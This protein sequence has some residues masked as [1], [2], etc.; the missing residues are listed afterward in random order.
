MLENKKSFSCVIVSL[1]QNGDGIAYP[2]RPHRSK[3]YVISSESSVLYRNNPPF[4]AISS[5]A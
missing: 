1:K 3:D 2:T 4:K 5:S